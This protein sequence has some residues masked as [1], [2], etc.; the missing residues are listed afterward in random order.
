MCSLMWSSSGKYL[1]FRN[2]HVAFTSR[3]HGIYDAFTLHL[4]RIRPYGR[5]R[6]YDRIRPYGPI[7]RY[8]RIRPYG[9]NRYL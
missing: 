6:L 3:S 1:F 9:C 5:I 7:R 2:V 8:G 4:R